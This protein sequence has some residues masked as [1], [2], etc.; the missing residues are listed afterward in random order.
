MTEQMNVPK[1][2][3]GE[4]S[5]NW[6]A[7]ELGELM[8]FKNGIN[9]S[10]EQYGR[11]VKFINVLD[12]IEN[13]YITYDRIVGSVDVEDKEFQKNIVEHGDILFQRSSET[14]EDVGQANVYLDEKKVA[15]FG[16]F[17]IRGKKI[18]EFDSICMNY[19]LKTDKARKE[20]TTRSGGSTRYNV[21]QATLSAVNIHL[22]PSISE[23]Q[24]VASFLSKVDEKIALL[25]EK[26]TKL[27]KYKK[28]VMQKLFNGKWQEQDGQLTFIP[29]TLRFKADDGSEFPD[30]EEDKIGNNTEQ[31][32][33][34]AFK[35]EDLIE[36]QGDYP[37]MRGINITEGNIRHSIEMDR[38]YSGD[39]SKLTK[40]ILEEHDL[41]IGMDGS[42]VGKNIALVT[43]DDVGALLVQ[44]VAR[45]RPKTNTSIMFIY[46]NIIAEKFRRYVDIVNTSS[47][48]PHISKKQIDDYKIGFPCF[49]EQ[50]KIASFLSA[51]DK[52]IDLTNSEL[53][54]AK[55]WKKGLLQ[56]MFV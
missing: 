17:V 14:R 42:K 49:D 10:K 18:G 47:G 24:K 46:Q 51:I 7:I 40:Y 21:G 39:I 33:G 16:G 41:V 31:L 32:N 6:Q 8:A 44:R 45:L 30:W 11:G 50:T 4:F 37:L 34:F 48:I 52:K 9:A 27:T 36:G 29:P 19:L 53:E 55:K 28:G 12:I 38:F 25:T 54:K 22:P 13:D 3:F 15:T 26:K 43:S 5:E 35:S 2:R 23:Q 56:Q 20:V 1:L